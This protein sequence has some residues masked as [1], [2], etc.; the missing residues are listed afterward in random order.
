MRQKHGAVFE[1]F[2]GIF[3]ESALERRL[4]EV[5]GDLPPPPPA[6]SSQ[7]EDN[8]YCAIRA[9]EAEQITYRFWEHVHFLQER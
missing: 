7:V 5:V 4:W 6:G 9:F 1:H 3:Q 8:A 2:S